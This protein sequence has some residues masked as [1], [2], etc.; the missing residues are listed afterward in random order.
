[1]TEPSW[2]A[3]APLRE[4]DSVTALAASGGLALAGTAAGLF[5]RDTGGPW[6]RLDLAA[7]EIQA[8]AFGDSADFVAAGAGSAVDVSRDGGVTWD[9]GE[10]ET[11][12]RVTALGISGSNMLAGTD[13]G[14]AFLSLNGGASWSACGLERQMVLAAN[15]DNLAGTDQG[16]W[17]RESGTKWRKLALEAVVTALARTEG[18]IVAGTEEE[19]LFRSTD[20]GA[21]W[22]K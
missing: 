16:L 9:R 7:T 22:Q 17:R 13:T 12:A 21:T 3:L 10:L 2:C 18:A 4:T 8:T 1:M 11:S 14:G 5:R 20:E 6:Q 15:G 19:G